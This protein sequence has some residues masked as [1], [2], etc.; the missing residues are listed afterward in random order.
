MGA[1]TNFGSDTTTNHC[2]IARGHAYTIVTTFD[3]T[4][5]GTTHNMLLMRNPWGHTTYDK[6]WNSN[7]P[8]WVAETL[9]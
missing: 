2:N 7:D 3:I 1:G 5:Q 4:Y 9:A 8:N 6:E